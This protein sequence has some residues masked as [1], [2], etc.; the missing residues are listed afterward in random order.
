MVQWVTYKIRHWWAVRCCGRKNSYR[1]VAGNSFE[2]EG[3]VEER[4]QQGWTG[5]DGHDNR[6]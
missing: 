6:K 4:C 2:L 1:F 3:K 5:S